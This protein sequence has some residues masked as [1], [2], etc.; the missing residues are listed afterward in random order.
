MSTLNGSTPKATYTALL[1]LASSGGITTTYKQ[2]E[3]G[4]GTTAPFYIKDS[5]VKVDALDIGSSLSS[6]SSGTVYA[7]VLESST[8]AVKTAQIGTFGRS[9]R[10]PYLGLYAFEASATMTVP[11]GA[12]WY[13]MGN[14]GYASGTLYTDQSP[15]GHFT[16]FGSVYDS[17][18]A[19]FFGG[20]EEGTMFQI[21]MRFTATPA[22]G[23]AADGGYIQFGVDTDGDNTPDSFF[24]T[25]YLPE[26]DT[27]DS[28]QTLTI[29]HYITSDINT[30]GA[31]IFCR[32]PSG[33]TN[34]VDLKNVEYLVEVLGRAK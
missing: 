25:V 26:G 20:G 5:S 19:L 30:N 6:A 12:T 33:G 24:Q 13:S 11:S 14:A 4:D 8:G 15:D 34:T 7:L 27:N 21:T 28:Y 16:S 3:A 17:S 22:A 10:D 31:E 9:N 1:K 29:R 2:L 23:H 18:G 32:T